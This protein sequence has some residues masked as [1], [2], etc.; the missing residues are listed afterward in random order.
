M[1]GKALSTKG[2]AAAISDTRH[3]HMLRRY[4]A[5]ALKRSIIKV[6]KEVVEKPVKVPLRSVM[7][8]KGVGATHSYPQKSCNADFSSTL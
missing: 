6:I 8:Q 4:L 5:E 2:T 1:R 7:L 3:L